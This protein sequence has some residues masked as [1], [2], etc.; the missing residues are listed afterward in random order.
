VLPYES[1]C[2]VYEY[3]AEVAIGAC[4][5]QE[6]ITMQKYRL[7]ISEMEMR[8]SGVFVLS[9]C[10][11]ALIYVAVSSPMNPD[12]S[13]QLVQ[14][15]NNPLEQLALT[16]LRTGSALAP[17]SDYKRKPNTLAAVSGSRNLPELNLDASFRSE[18]ASLV[19]LGLALLLGAGV[20][21]ALGISSPSKVNRK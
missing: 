10:I 21:R 19:V 13:E 3:P 12:Q 16:A 17:A 18:S 8:H 5:K 14:E 20:L 6:H 2:A 11:L 15:Y 1:A 9:S 7:E 4:A